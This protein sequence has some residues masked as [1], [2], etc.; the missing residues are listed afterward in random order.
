MGK[1]LRITVNRPISLEA[2]AWVNHVECVLNE[3][4]L[5]LERDERFR[6]M[7]RDKLVEYFETGVM[8]KWTGED[9]TKIEDIMQVKF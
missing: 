5:D 6:A 2:K 4:L 7:Y 1:S 8:P 9:L 3:R